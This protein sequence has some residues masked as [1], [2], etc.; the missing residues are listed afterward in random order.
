[1]NA[2]R[3]TH[4]RRRGFTL[5]ELLVVV[6]IIALLV[7]ILMPAL[8]KAREQARL[9][10]CQSNLRGIGQAYMIYAETYDGVFTI[11]RATLP[12]IYRD[13]AYN[14]D[15]TLEKRLE[16]TSGAG[17]LYEY[18]WIDTEDALFCPNCNK[19][20]P[21]A[22]PFKAPT[23][24]WLAAYC[25]R[26][27]F[28]G[29]WYGYI[30]SDIWYDQGVLRPL[31]IDKIRRT[32]VTGLMS[33]LLYNQNVSFH[34]NTWNVVFMDTHVANVGDPDGDLIRYMTTN[35][36]SYSGGYSYNAWKILESNASGAAAG[37]Y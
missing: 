22:G 15:D 32:A 37:D 7:S 3:V 26:P 24:N 25:N 9:V 29:T 28:G 19:V 36:P 27:F 10:M 30:S 6:S 33:D 16:H 23:W 4:C 11:H 17:K 34:Q 31:T 20:W 35:P 14:K 1:M 13:A 12:Y 2:K 8:G 5:I 18:Q 21:Y